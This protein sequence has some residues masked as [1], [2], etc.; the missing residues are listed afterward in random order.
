MKVYFEALTMAH[1]MKDHF[2]VVDGD[3]SET[4]TGKHTAPYKGHY[5]TDG[6]VCNCSWFSNRKLCRHPFVYRSF[7]NL[8]LFDLKMFHSSFRINPDSD[9][10]DD[11]NTSVDMFDRDV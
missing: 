6:Y 2:E 8:P 4:Y 5:K 7:H 1:D 9:E 10:I 11:T 3:I